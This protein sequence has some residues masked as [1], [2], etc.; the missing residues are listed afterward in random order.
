MI[1]LWVLVGLVVGLIAL[2]GMM[3][4]IGWGLPQGHVASRRARFGQPPEALWEAITDVDAFPTWRPDVKRVER[5]PDRDGRPVWREV[6][7]HGAITIEQVDAQPPRRLVGRIADPGLPFGGT[8]TYE[9][10]A[11]EGGSTLAITENGEVYNPVFRFMSRYIF[12]HHGTMETYLKALGKKLGE[13]VVPEPAG[14]E[15]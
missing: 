4:L 7:R 8:W 1:W 12:G 9:I 15:T 13:T 5:L 11:V 3:A 14:G 6:G 10:A 2:V